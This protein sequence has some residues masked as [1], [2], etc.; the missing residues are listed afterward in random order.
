ME[1]INKNVV[2]KIENFGAMGDKIR[3]K[4]IYVK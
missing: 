4:N 3:K 2:K 1:E